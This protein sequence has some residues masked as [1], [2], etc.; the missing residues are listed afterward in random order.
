MSKKI[1]MLCGE[2]V[3]EKEAGYVDWF[4]GDEL[5]K[6]KKLRKQKET[7]CM[8]CKKIMLYCS[9]ISPFK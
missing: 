8:D 4:N 2:R 7:I 5:S 1:C 9:I 6:L 3:S